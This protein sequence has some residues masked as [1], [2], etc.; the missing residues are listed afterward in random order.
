M[1]VN[2][3]NLKTL[4]RM[5][6]CHFKLDKFEDSKKEIEV[7]FKII[8][9]NGGDK[10]PFEMLLKDINN[11]MQNLEQSQDNLLKKMVKNK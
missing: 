8:N 11:R 2:K 4:Y 7:A 9:K 1:R 5:A 3:E 6:F 10:T